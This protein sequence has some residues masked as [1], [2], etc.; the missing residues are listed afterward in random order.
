MRTKLAIIA[1]SGFVVSA[2]S[3]GGAF[4]LG[5]N[6]IG[7]AVFNFDGFDLPRCDRVGAN[8]TADSRSIAWDGSDHAS[9]ALPADTHYRAG[10]GDQLIVRGDP[11]LVSH[12]RVRNGVV[13]LD[14]HGGSLFGNSGHLD[15]TLPGKRQFRAFEVMGSGTMDLYGLSQPDVKLSVVGNGTIEADAK[16]KNLKMDVAGSGTLTARG[17]A[18]QLDVNVSGSGKIRAGELATKDAD[19]DVSGS[20]HIEVAAENSLDVDVSGSGTIFLKT[21]PK[22]LQT[23]ISGSGTIVHPN[24]ERQ[25]RPSR[26]H[27]RLEDK[28]AVRAAVLQALAESDNRHAERATDDD[29][30]RAAQ[31]LGAR[32]RAKVAKELANAKIDSDD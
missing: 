9:I 31:D 3:L 2:V 8:P 29:V 14:C 10:S 32:I 18:D 19:I 16:V 1:V 11:L 23:D 15:V 12:V 20:G 6:A 22:S 25:G 7:D 28:E 24:G 27:A 5:G 4:A 30:Q 17:Q 13:G 21:E 26:R